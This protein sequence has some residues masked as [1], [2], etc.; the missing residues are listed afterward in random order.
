MQ[1]PCIKE[2]P[3]YV[4]TKQTNIIWTL[5]NQMTPYFKSKPYQGDPLA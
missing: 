4:C 1:T 3:H 5:C 2:T